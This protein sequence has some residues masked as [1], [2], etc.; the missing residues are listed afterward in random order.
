[1][2]Y[3]SQRLAPRRV[4]RQLQKC[5]IPAADNWVWAH[6]WRRPVSVAEAQWDLANAYLL[7]GLMARPV[8]L[9]ATE[10]T[11]WVGEL[12]GGW[13]IRLRSFPLRRMTQ[14]TLS[15]DPDDMSQMC[16]QFVFGGVSHC[17]AVSRQAQTD[18]QQQNWVSLQALLA[19]AGIASKVDS[20]Y[21]NQ[22]GG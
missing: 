22:K 3:L 9:V 6:C 10:A 17:Y 11:L 8:V 18:A 15:L 19:P 13:L 14:M 12:I 7:A 16:L 2:I 1:M 21:N 4:E 20:M 5:G